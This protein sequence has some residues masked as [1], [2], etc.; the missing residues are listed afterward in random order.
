MNRFLN[1]FVDEHVQENNKYFTDSD[2]ESLA[3][4]AVLEINYIKQAL[5][6]IGL[7]YMGTPAY[8]PSHSANDTLQRKFEAAFNKFC[9][10][11]SSAYGANTFDG[12]D[13]NV[14]IIISFLINGDDNSSMVITD[15]VRHGSIEYS[16][17]SDMRIHA[18]LSDSK[19]KRC[20]GQVGGN[21]KNSLSQFFEDMI[22]F[23]KKNEL[24]KINDILKLK[25]VSNKVQNKTAEMTKLTRCTR[26]EKVFDRPLND[27]ICTE[28]SQT[29]Q[30]EKKL[31][32][33]Y[34]ITAKATDYN[35]K[36]K[37]LKINIAPTYHI[38]LPDNILDI[39]VYLFY[40]KDENSQDK[41]HFVC[42]LNVIYSTKY[43]NY[44]ISGKQLNAIN[45]YLKSNDF[46]NEVSRL[47]I[48]YEPCIGHFELL[49]GSS[50]INLALTDSDYIDIRQLRGNYV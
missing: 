27:D 24:A 18:V 9:S 40:G 22:Q 23:A 6:D 38:M 31:Q 20:S 48:G 41:K 34:S 19:S 21:Y 35:T 25:Q 47:N 13:D 39:K 17:Y 36:I 45:S 29:Q 2:L 3:Q 50:K 44:K 26:C 32:L 12:L 11:L 30:N 10:A 15:K 4:E 8:K 43:H 7:V 1:L 46:Y 5:S 33:S 28:C 49:Y 14:Y 16:S 37:S 42:Q